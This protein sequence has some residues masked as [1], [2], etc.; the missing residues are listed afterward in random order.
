MDSSFA[1]HVGAFTNPLPTI[2]LFC[3]V[4][5]GALPDSCIGK[6]QMRQSFHPPAIPIHFA[7]ITSFPAEY[8]GFELHHVTDLKASEICSNSL[9]SRSLRLVRFAPNA[10]FPTFCGAGVAGHTVSGMLLVS[11]LPAI[12]VRLCVGTKSA[13]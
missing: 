10:R 6:E 1:S 3:V 11:G 5:E 12:Y 9:G 2:R 13:L 4:M 7:T 8:A